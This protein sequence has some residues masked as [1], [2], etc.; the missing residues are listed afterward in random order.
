[1]IQGFWTLLNCLEMISK[2]AMSWEITRATPPPSNSKGADSWK[3]FLGTSS[4]SHSGNTGNY[5]V[6]DYMRNAF[7]IAQQKFPVVCLEDIQ[8]HITFGAMGDSYYEYLLKLCAARDGFLQEIAGCR[9]FPWENPLKIHENPLEIRTFFGGNS[10]RK[11]AAVFGTDSTD[12]DHQSEI[13]LSPEHQ[14]VLGIFTDFAGPKWVDNGWKGKAHWFSRPLPAKSRH[15]LHRFSSLNSETIVQKQ[16]DGLILGYRFGYAM[17]SWE[18][19]VLEGTGFS[20]VFSFCL[21]FEQKMV[22]PSLARSLPVLFFFGW[23]WLWL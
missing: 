8:G 3:W 4:K 16:E 18:S 6:G 19:T 13:P 9:G 21:A 17:P 12:L 10:S 22:L 1:M 11:N 14:S 7:C 20:Q 23:L 5:L 2:L 15:V